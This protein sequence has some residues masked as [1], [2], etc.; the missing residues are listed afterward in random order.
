MR[1]FLSQYIAWS[2]HFYEFDT[3]IALGKNVEVLYLVNEEISSSR[4]FLYKWNLK[5]NSS[6]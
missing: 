1:G 4:S 6:P 5:Y 2:I 3:T